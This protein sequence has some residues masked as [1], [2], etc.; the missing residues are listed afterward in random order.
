VSGHWPHPSVEEMT[1]KE[2]PIEIEWPKE[3]CEEEREGLRALLTAYDAAI[4]DFESN[5]TVIFPSDGER[6]RQFYAF[7]KRWDKAWFTRGPRMH[8]GCTAKSIARSHTIPLAA[9]IRLI[10]EDG[11]VVTPR[12]GANGIELARIGVHEASTFPGFCEEHEAQFAGFETKKHMTEAEHF[13]LQAFRTMPE[14][15]QTKIILGALAL[16]L[17]AMLCP[18]SIRRE[19]CCAYR[20][21]VRRCPTIVS[22]RN[23]PTVIPLRGRVTMGS[24]SPQ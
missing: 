7:I 5:H 1:D 14:A 11:H 12:F 18:H 8:D 23:A 24:T 6:K 2:K 3:I 13:Q 9:S 17:L 16:S 19:M 21:D 20:A 22:S 4:E 10:A 15:G